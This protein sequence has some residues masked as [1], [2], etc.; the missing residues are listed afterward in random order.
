M[1]TCSPLPPGGLAEGFEPHL[2]ETITHFERGRDDRAELHLGRRIQ[3]EHQSTGNFRIAF[4]AVPRMELERTDLRDRDERLDAIDLHIGRLVASHLDKG[5]QIR[6]AGHGMALKELLTVDSVRRA[7]QRA[8]TAAQMRQQ[9]LA[10]G[11]VIAGEIELGD[12][13]ARIGIG[14]Q[15]LVGV[16][17]RH[18]HHDVR[19]AREAA[20]GYGRSFFMRLGGCFSTCGL[21]PTPVARQRLR[22]QACRAAIL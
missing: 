4:R 18:S 6:D 10:D 16:R 3:I 11:F 5:E 14:P 22:S 2:L 20:P 19:P 8:R 1:T 15:H 13:V 9:P 17:Q 12:G 21:V 7:H